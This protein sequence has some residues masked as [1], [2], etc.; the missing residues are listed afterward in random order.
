MAARKT[1]SEWDRIKREYL[2]GDDSIREIAD[3]HEISEAAIRKRAKVDGWQRPVR[4]REPVRT[5]LPV[6]RQAPIAPA[7][8]PEPVANAEIAE[9]ARQIVA[10]M[11]DE[12]DT[13]T[14]YQGE[15]EE[16]IEAATA[17]DEDDSRRDAMMRATSLPVR[18]AVAKNLAA[19]LKT[20]N[21]AAGPQQGKKAAAQERAT[22]VGK[23]FGAMGAPTGASKL[24]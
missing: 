3:R 23:K 8:R 18:S 21:E 2:E 11:F 19:A 1:S 9:N 4:T 17:D 14:T 7:P 6:P 16:I 10:R 20:I 22:A 5:L 24:N 12:L 13:V 15:L